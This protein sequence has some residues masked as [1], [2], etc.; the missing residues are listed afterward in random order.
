MP[1]TVSFKKIRWAGFSWIF[2][3]TNRFIATISRAEAP[4]T[5]LYS[6]RSVFVGVDDFCPY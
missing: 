6:L 5:T 4:L 1:Y 3:H 2:K